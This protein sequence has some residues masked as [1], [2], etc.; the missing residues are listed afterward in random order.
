M[1]SIV[2]M[3]A[4][5]C[6]DLGL[7]HAWVLPKLW[8]Q[9]PFEPSGYTAFIWAQGRIEV[10]ALDT[11]IVV[12]LQQRPPEQ[13]AVV[14]ALAAGV[15]SDDASGRIRDQAVE[16]HLPFL[17]ILDAADALVPHALVDDHRRRPAKSRLRAEQHVVRRDPGLGR[18]PLH[19]SL[20][21]APGQQRA[22][23]VTLLAA[24]LVDVSAGLHSQ[25]DPR[26]EQEAHRLPWV[27]RVGCVTAAEG[28]GA[29][30]RVR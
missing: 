25:R 30:C 7:R 6:G 4:C 2:S 23:L 17:L 20:V 27:V 5:Q 13:V 3:S 16:R 22:H 26:L 8:Y 24:G 29:A 15:S 18:F 11:A 19:L 1:V 9:L 10:F 21:T 14:R 28:L 12:L